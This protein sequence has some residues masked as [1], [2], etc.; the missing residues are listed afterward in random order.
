MDIV[1]FVMQKK[2]MAVSPL[3]SDLTKEVLAEVT[4]MDTGA[5]QIS[6]TAGEL[7]LLS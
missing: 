2:M 3:I 5:E 6:S 1:G 7:A 4:P